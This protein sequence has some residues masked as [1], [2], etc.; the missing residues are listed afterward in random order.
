MVPGEGL[1]GHYSGWGTWGHSRQGFLTASRNVSKS[2]S[3]PIRPYFASW[4]NTSPSHIYD[5]GIAGIVS[6]KERFSRQR[7][8]TGETNDSQAQPWS[9]SLRVESVPLLGQGTS[10]SQ[11][12][13]VPRDSGLPVSQFQDG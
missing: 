1:G 12:C 9:T 3:Q 2:F 6:S 8:R 11:L 5:S 4:L 13:T 10:L 7:G